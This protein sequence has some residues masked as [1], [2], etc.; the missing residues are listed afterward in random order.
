MEYI[1][2]KKYRF[3]FANSGNCIS[4][5]GSLKLSFNEPIT[6]F[7][8]KFSMMV[9]RDSSGIMHKIVCNLCL[10]HPVMTTGNF[11]KRSVF[12]LGHRYQSIFCVQFK[13]DVAN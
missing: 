9:K 10:F 7:G 8:R 13:L 2:T 3:L 12:F 4:V 11:Y 5:L 1:Y 6:E